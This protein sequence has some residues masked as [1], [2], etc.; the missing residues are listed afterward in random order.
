[1]DW[2]ITLMERLG[3]FGIF[4]LVLLENLIPPIPSEVVLPFAGFMTTT[5]VVRLAGVIGASAA[6]SVLGAVALYGLGLWIGR[7]RIQRI[8][9]RHQRWL[10]VTPDHLHEATRWFTRYGPAA[11]FLCRMVPIM[12][13]IISIPAGLVRMPLF[14]FCLY[15]LFGSLIWNT[16]LVGLGALLGASWRTVVTW[17]TYYH[18]AVTV[19]AAVAFLIIAANFVRKRRIR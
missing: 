18:H 13:S 5:G 2:A 9:E 15:T 11:V 3:Y 10:G 4:L 19:L 8:V 16:A 17:I 1:M 6:G 14:T 7:D 12:R